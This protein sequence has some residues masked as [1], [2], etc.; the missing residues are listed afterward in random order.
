VPPPQAVLLTNGA[1]WRYLDDGSDQGTG[2]RAVDFDDSAWAAGPA[3][4][5]YGDGDEATVV[6]FGADP[7]LKYITTYFRHAFMMTN[8]ADFSALTVQLLRDDGGVV[9]LNGVE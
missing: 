7:N 6:S 2:W 9:Y 5:G 1:S 3:Q 8:S 4:L